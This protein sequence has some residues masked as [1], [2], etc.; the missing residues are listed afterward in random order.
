VPRPPLD[1][2]ADGAARDIPLLIGTNLDEWRLFSATDPDV[3]SVDEHELET[4]VGA[5]LGGDPRKAIDTYRRRLG[6]APAKLVLDCV[7]TD[8]TFRAPA[9][10]LAEAQHRAGGS[11]HMYLFTWPSTTFGGAL[12]SF[13][14]LELPFVFDTLETPSANVICG[15]A[16]P[17]ALAEAMQAAWT[18]FAHTGD[19]SGVPLGQ[20]PRYRPAERTT[21]VLEAIPHLEDD[22]LGDERLLWAD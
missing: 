16:P 1:A 10:R 3:W 6:E 4:R 15:D 7:G 8:V 19:P 20:W 11:A 14:G 9:V 18:A 21:M 12:G 22:P 13:H 2:V 17:R 5:L